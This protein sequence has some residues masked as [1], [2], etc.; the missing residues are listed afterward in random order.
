[1]TILEELISDLPWFQ[2]VLALT[3]TLPSDMPAPWDNNFLPGEIV[4]GVV[5]IAI[6][7]VYIADKMLFN[8]K[9]R[10]YTNHH[11]EHPDCSSDCPI[12]ISYRELFYER[13]ILLDLIKQGLQHFIEKTSSFRGFGKILSDWRVVSSSDVN[14]ESD[15]NS[16]EEFSLQNMHPPSDE[17]KKRGS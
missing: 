17:E 4:L 13:T 6:R 1:M 11:H 2:D 9:G 14:A 3:N 7:K 12:F 8:Q 15:E 16:I 10:E 5:P